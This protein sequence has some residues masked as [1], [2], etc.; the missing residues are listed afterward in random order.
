MTASSVPPSQR[1]EL[2]EAMSD[3]AI[4]GKLVLQHCTACQAVQY[5]PRDIC[6]N[7]LC[8]DL[9]WRETAPQGTLLAAA[10]LHH[11]HETYFQER[12]PWTVASVQ[13]DSGP[14]LF[15]HAAQ[16]AIESGT[17]V[18]VFTQ[19]DDSGKA[20]LIATALDNSADN[21]LILQQMGLA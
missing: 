11:S 20:V 1:T 4:A 16:D 21:A 13:L 18:R 3:A 7:C 12:L 8:D 2:G 9:Q 15:V 17:R 14:I 19:I 10:A 6:C 5:P